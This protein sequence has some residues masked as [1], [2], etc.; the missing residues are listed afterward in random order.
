MY[1]NLYE[2][3][4]HIRLV[5]GGRGEFSY[6]Y[7]MILTRNSKSRPNCGGHIFSFCSRTVGK[8]E[9][10]ITGGDSVPPPTSSSYHLVAHLV[11]G[12]P[13]RVLIWSSRT[14]SYAPGYIVAPPFVVPFVVSAKKSRHFR[15]VVSMLSSHFSVL[16]VIRATLEAT[17]S[18]EDFAVYQSEVGIK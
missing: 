18:R 7:R 15:V 8:N 17:V 12:S 16:G 4:V 6:G 5:T 3:L 11:T 14:P 1:E 2:N 9:E 13:H 10:K